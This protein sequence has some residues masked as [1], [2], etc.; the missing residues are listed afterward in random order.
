MTI[1]GKQVL[2]GQRWVLMNSII[3]TDWFPFQVKKIHFKKFYGSS[4]CNWKQCI[5]ITICM[6]AFVVWLWYITWYACTNLGK[7][8]SQ[9]RCLFAW[10]SYHCVQWGLS[11]HRT[12]L[13]QPNPMHDF[14]EFSP[15]E[16]PETYP[17]GSAYRNGCQPLHKGWRNMESLQGMPS[18]I[19]PP[20]RRKRGLHLLGVSMA[21]KRVQGA[22]APFCRPPYAPCCNYDPLLVSWWNTLGTVLQPHERLLFQPVERKHKT[23][24]FWLNSKMLLYH[25]VGGRFVFV[26][27]NKPSLNRSVS[28]CL[29]IINR[30]Q[31]YFITSLKKNNLLKRLKNAWACKRTWFLS[32][33]CLIIFPLLIA[34]RFPTASRP[35]FQ[36]AMRHPNLESK[37]LQFTNMFC[38]AL[39]SQ[40]YWIF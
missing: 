4:Y 9:F 13:L 38:A 32:R 40:S 25:G 28:L 15:T 12:T 21:F 26:C 14:S 27:F 36:S 24:I 2:V 5:C 29:L 6:C 3:M 19:A 7:L 1:C 30:F 17:Q 18:V 31:W 10:K 22:H 8:V 39:C 37:I 20:Q 11:V 34:G 35:T 33:Y 16:F 23:S